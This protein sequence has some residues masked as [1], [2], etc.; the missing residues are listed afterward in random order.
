VAAA[1]AGSVPAMISAAPLSTGAEQERVLRAA[2]EAGA[3]RAAGWLGGLLEGRDPAEAERWYRLAIERGDLRRRISLADLLAGQGRD[4]EAEELYRTEAE[5]DDQEAL[6][7]L[8]DLLSARGRRHEA[9][10]WRRRAEELGPEGMASGHGSSLETVVATA[11]VTT[12]LVPFLQALAG[13]AAEDVYAALRRLAG[14]RPHT[15]PPADREAE[16]LVVED[17]DGDVALYV[18]LDDSDEALRALAE[19]D[20]QRLLRNRF[21]AGTAALVW[22]RAAHAWRLRAPEEERR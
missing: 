4:A 16:L 8:I 19:L 12:A 22:D 21:W 15:R 2:A 17:P 7:R 9:D 13:K 10:R 20:P 14:R 18:W 6:R 3:R 5:R 11:A 1:T